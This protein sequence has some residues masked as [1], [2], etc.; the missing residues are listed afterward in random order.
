ML[1]ACG[2]HAIAKS[3]RQLQGAVEKRQRV[4]TDTIRKFRW[5]EVQLELSPLLWLVDQ[6]QVLEA[7]PIQT[8]TSPGLRL[9]NGT[10]FFLCF[11]MMCLFLKLFTHCSLTAPFT[12]VMNFHCE[13]HNPER[14]NAQAGIPHSTMDSSIPKATAPAPSWLP[15]V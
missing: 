4:K 6:P 11:G 5:L 12:Y 9:M 3:G 15:P 7:E 14:K 8:Q 10:I 13:R 2:Q 1:G